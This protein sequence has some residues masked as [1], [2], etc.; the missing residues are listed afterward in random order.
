MPCLEN[1]T[2][3][4]TCCRLRLLLG[5]K[6]FTVASPVN[7]QNDCVYASSN[8][9]KSDIAPERLLSCRPTFASSLTVSVAVSKLG[10][11]KLFFV[12]PGVKVDG[13]Y[14]GEVLLKKHAGCQ[15]CVALLVTRTCFSRAAHRRTVLA[16]QFSCSSRRRHTIYLPRS[17]VY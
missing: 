12:E 13:R 17:V 14:Y 10:C 9:K 15:S 11:T 5:Q 8:A 1:D 16:R 2:A 3:F 4:G 7:L 6:V